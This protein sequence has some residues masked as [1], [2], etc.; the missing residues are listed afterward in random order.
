ML[1]EKESNKYVRLS[2][3]YAIKKFPLK[4][5]ESICRPLAMDK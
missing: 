5:H 3:I 1:V 2:E 4:G